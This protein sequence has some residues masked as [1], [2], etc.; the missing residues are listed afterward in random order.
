MIIDRRFRGPPESGHGGYVCGVV[1][2]LIGGTAEV[3][4]R[5][6]PPLGRPLEV[7]RHDGSGISLRD[8][9]TVVA[10]GA[11]ASVEIDVPGPVGFSDA[12]VA[13]RSYIGLRKPAFPTCFGCG[14]QRAEGD[15]LRLFAGRV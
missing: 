1:A 15:G 7:M 5:R 6:P 2:G 9:Q 13:S 4:L 14:T 11:P 10:E 12:E 3:T 8:D